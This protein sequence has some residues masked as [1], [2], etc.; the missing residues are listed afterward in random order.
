[1]YVMLML[2]VVPSLRGQGCG[3]TIFVLEPTYLYSHWIG[4]EVDSTINNVVSVNG[5]D[6]YG[7][8]N[9]VFPLHCDEPEVAMY[10]Y[11]DRPLTIIG[12][13]ANIAHRI[14]FYGSSDSKSTDYFRLWEIDETNDLVL[15][16]SMP[17]PYSFTPTRK[18]EFK[19][20]MKPKCLFP[21]AETYKGVFDVVEFYFNSPTVVEDSFY[22]GL[23][24]YGINDGGGRSLVLGDV[25]YRWWGPTSSPCPNV[26][27]LPYEQQ[28]RR[29]SSDCSTWEY[30][31]RS[32]AM[33]MWPIFDTTGMNVFNPLD[34]MVCA[35]VE[36]LHVLDQSGDGYFLTWT[37]QSGQY[38][39]QLA[40]GPEGS[41]P[42]ECE[43]VECSTSYKYLYGIDTTSRTVVYVR[44]YCGRNKWGDWSDGLVI[45]ALNDTVDDGGGEVTT[46]ET[47]PDRFVTLAP[48][49]G[50]EWVK[51]MS[52][53][54]MSGVKVMDASGRVLKEVETSGLDT[55]LDVRD[56]PTGTYFVQV[57]TPAGTTTKKFVKR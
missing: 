15:L 32:E 38:R 34:T 21:N 1:M 33:L 51:V 10:F 30:Y 26:D 25:W 7:G 17:M 41:C 54:G 55:D 37:G 43:V 29:R 24:N 50:S 19:Y 9:Y 6:A 20:R 8:W 39:W 4:D 23:T 36:G 11:T 31:S 53:F 57:R 42:E 16:N 48:N 49:P 18:M 28:Y 45:G 52:S 22:V 14:G 35:Q 56:W 2:A 46:G 27:V 12:V 5:E 47:L 3:D 40:Y 44:G 13:A